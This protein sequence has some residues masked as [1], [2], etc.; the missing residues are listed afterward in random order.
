[1]LIIVAM[2]WYIVRVV[3]LRHTGRAQKMTESYHILQC[4]FIITK[5][6]HYS[7]QDQDLLSEC[8]LYEV[9]IFPLPSVI[10]ISENSS[11]TSF[12]SIRTRVFS[13]II[14]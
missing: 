8:K 9:N 3:M 11:P 6:G 10:D 1:M 13:G 14:L 2:L 5:K 7:I 4:R 12:S